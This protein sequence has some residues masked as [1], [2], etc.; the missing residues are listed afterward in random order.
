MYLE[1]NYT[2][3]FKQKITGYAVITGILKSYEKML[4]LPYDLFLKISNHE[5]IDNVEVERRLFNRIG[6]RYVDAYKFALEEYK[7][8]DD[9]FKVYEWWLRTHMLIDHISGMTDEFALQTY[10]M[11]KGINLMRI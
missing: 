7:E 10:Q 9:D 8:C 6:Q 5:K 2:H 3:Q 11:L 1:K 4:K